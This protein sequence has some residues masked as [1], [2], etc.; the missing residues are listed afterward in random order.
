MSK[1][2]GLV[3][4]LMSA[5]TMGVEQEFQIS[6]GPSVTDGTAD[7]WFELTNESGNAAEELRY[8][9]VSIGK[10]AFGGGWFGCSGSGDAAIELISDEAT[11]KVVDPGDVLRVRE[12]GDGMNLRASD[13]GTDLWITMM[14]L[15]PSQRSSGA[16]TCTWNA[17]WSS[18]W[19]VG[20]K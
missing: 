19:R 17:V 16:L 8:Y 1:A 11:P 3:V 18:P 4:V 6:P 10:Q 5:C 15:D 13:N 14:V 7:V 2:I 20:V 12:D 9:R